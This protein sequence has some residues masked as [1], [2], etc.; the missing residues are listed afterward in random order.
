[1]QKKYIFIG[2]SLVLGLTMGSI[3]VASA[4]VLP[5]ITPKFGG[6]AQLQITSADHGDAKEITKVK[7]ALPGLF[8]G[9]IELGNLNAGERRKLYFGSNSDENYKHLLK[10]IESI[11]VNKDAQSHLSEFRDAFNADNEYSMDR[12]FEKVSLIVDS[13]RWRKSYCC[14][15]LAL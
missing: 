12:S 9:N 4:K 6:L 15:H 14:F 5:E 1:M 7:A 11:W 8:E 2:S 3:A 13:G 10:Q